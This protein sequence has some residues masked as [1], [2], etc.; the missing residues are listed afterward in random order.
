MRSVRRGLADIGEALKEATFIVGSCWSAIIKLGIH[1]QTHHDL[2]FPQV[3]T[4]LDLRNC[5]AIYDE[6]NR[7]DTRFR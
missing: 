1:L 5:P 4:V 2:T 7:P 3:S 6:S